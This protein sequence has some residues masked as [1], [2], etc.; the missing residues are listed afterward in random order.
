METKFLLAGDSALSVQL[1]DEIS[2]KV[3]RRVRMLFLNL[4][5]VPIEGIREMV[6][7]YAALMIHYHPDQIGVGRLKEEILRRMEHLEEAEVSESVVKEIPV[8]YGGELGPDLGECAAMEHI[9]EEE[10]IRMHSSH[11]Y[12][13]YMLGFAPGHAYT[14]R[15]EE[16]FHFKR[17]ES[18]RVS[19]PAGS[20]AVQLNL[21]NPIPFA[22]PCGWNIIGSTPLTLCD[23]SKEDPFVLHAGD[24]IRYVSVTTEEYEQIKRDIRKG[25]Y[26]VK[27]YEK[28]VR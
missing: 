2:L 15:F 25:T 28:V 17:R 21:S 23:Y 1:G 14:A 26:R 20:I 9:S 27:S 6:P 18:P 22:Q 19:V 12:Y 4:T 7:T 16:A 11:E 3:N 8:C 13:C 10:L 24:W 5:A